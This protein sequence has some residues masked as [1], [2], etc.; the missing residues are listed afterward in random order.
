[1][2]GYYFSINVQSNHP[3]PNNSIFVI[4]SCCIVTLRFRNT[5]NAFKVNIEIWSMFVK[6]R[7]PTTTRIAIAYS[8]VVNLHQVCSATFIKQYARTFTYTTQKKIWYGQKSVSQ[9]LHRNIDPFQLTILRAPQPSIG[10]RNKA[11][12]EVTL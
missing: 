3:T 6:T 5:F 8:P 12:S 4:N 10:T 11:Y 9:Y 7:H 2:N 1:M